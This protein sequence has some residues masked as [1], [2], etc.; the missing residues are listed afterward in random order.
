MKTTIHIILAFVL[1]GLFSCS[2]KDILMY[3]DDPAVY[4]EMPGPNGS[5]IRDSLVF[6]FPTITDA[7][8]VLNVRVRLMGYAAAQDRAISL[9]IN[10]EESDAQENTHFSLPQNIV[11]PASKYFVDIPLTIKRAGLENK[12]V[13]LVLDIVPNDNFKVGFVRG[14]SAI[15]R[16]GDMYIKPDNWDTSNYLSCWGPYSQFKYG[17][18]LSTCNI[19][20]LPDPMDIYTLGYYNELVRKA[21]YD[22]NASHDVPLQ[23]ETGAEITIPTW[24]GGGGGV[25]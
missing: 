2:E 6:S 15:I 18:I 3:E 17:F 12:S 13:R 23:D 9:N 25:G 5:G 24:N 22:Y 20:E 8:K 11:L 19:T 14:Q 21:L 4:F 1:F 16:W 10:P 7:T